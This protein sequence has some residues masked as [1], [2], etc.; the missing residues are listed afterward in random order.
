[1]VSEQNQMHRRGDVRRESLDVIRR[2]I[3]EPRRQAYILKRL[4]GHD[5]ARRS[6]V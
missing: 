1:M 6:Q 3:L 5:G 4:G 2:V